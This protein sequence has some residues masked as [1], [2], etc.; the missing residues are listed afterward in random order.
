MTSLPTERGASA[1]EYGLLISGV[2]AIIMATVLLFGGAV[3]EMFTD[4][5]DEMTA[6]TS[7][8]ADCR[9]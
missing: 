1:V 6:Q 2:A 3:T 4:S 5:C 9:P 7:P 8:G